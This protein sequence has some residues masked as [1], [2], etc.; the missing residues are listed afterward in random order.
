MQDT[1][2][3]AKS[4]SLVA[5]DERKGGQRRLGF[6][7]EERGSRKVVLLRHELEASLEGLRRPTRVGADQ[8]AEGIIRDG[9]R[10]C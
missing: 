10:H 7:H 8:P 1:V 3:E 4:G 5:V 9:G 2:L 6:A